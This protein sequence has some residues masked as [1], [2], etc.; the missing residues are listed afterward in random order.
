MSEPTMSRKGLPAAF[1][2]IG[3]ILLFLIA[4][5][6]VDWLYAYEGG[7]EDY[8]MTCGLRWLWYHV[9]AGGMALAFLGGMIVGGLFVHLGQYL[10]V[11][12]DTHSSPAST[13]AK[14]ER[15]MTVGHDELAAKFLATHGE[16]A[17]VKALPPGFILG[18][19]TQYGPLA[20]EIIEKFLNANPTPAP[21]SGGGVS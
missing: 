7:S 3:M 19:I 20:L 13:G 4:I 18:L 9:P 14:T 8:T 16:H 5:G 15:G 12:E 1:T 10:Y 21:A 11:S 2:L 6:V 17:A